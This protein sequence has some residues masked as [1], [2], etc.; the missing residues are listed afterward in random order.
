MVAAPVMNAIHFQ[1]EFS[2]DGIHWTTFGS[3]PITDQN[4][5]NYSLHHAFGGSCTLYYRVKQTDKDGKFT[6]S[7]VVIT[8]PITN[9]PVRVY[10]N[11]ANGIVNIVTTGD[12]SQASIRLLDVTGRILRTGKMNGSQHPIET[13]NL[14]DGTYLVQAISNHNIFS[15]KIVVRH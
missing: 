2:T 4:K 1:T 10:P 12:F 7:K 11:P 15:Q 6:Y 3:T 5:T 13:K 9:M 14:P 8:N